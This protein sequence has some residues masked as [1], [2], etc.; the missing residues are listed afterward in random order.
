MYPK[1]TQ[2]SNRMT[3]NYF[4]SR[5]RQSNYIA[6]RVMAS[7]TVYFVF[8]KTVACF[9]FKYPHDCASFILEMGFFPGRASP[10]PSADVYP[11][12][13]HKNATEVNLDNVDFLTTK[14]FDS[15]EVISYNSTFARAH[16]PQHKQLVS[17]DCYT[18]TS[19]YY[20]D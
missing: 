18:D 13:R 15:D 14:H 3:T 16:T 6:K 5:R 4:T 19:V 17:L 8:H 20:N 1:K 2:V 12:F 7:R 9:F 10:T 11:S